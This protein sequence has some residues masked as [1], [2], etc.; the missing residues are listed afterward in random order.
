MD[1]L[2]IRLCGTGGQGLIL[3]AR[4]LTEALVAEGRRVA[5]SQSYEPTS[6][7]GASRADLVIA[8]AIP[9]YPLATALDLALILDQIAM[10]ETGGLIRPGA[11]VLVDALRVPEPPEGD[12][13]VHA[14]PFTATARRL[15]SERVTNIVGLAALVAMARPCRFESLERAVRARAPRAMLDL[16]LEALNA[17]RHLAPERPVVVVAEAGG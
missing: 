6:R 12:F 11:L 3:A 15:G 13:V 8:D 1:E 17:G 9:D 14:L 5:Q 10:P 2:Q 4:I 7:G 16:N